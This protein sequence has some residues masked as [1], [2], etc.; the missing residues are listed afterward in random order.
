VPIAHNFGAH[1]K[2][3]AVTSRWQ[4]LEDLVGSGIEHHT[5]HSRSRRLTFFVKYVNG[6]IK[7]YR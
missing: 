7:T 4:C 3:T 2:F 1:Y 5:S 6:L